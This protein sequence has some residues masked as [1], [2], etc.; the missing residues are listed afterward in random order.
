MRLTTSLS[1]VS[2]LSRKCG[3]FDVSQPYRPQRPVTGITLPFYKIYFVTGMHKGLRIYGQNTAH[4]VLLSTKVSHSKW[5]VN[6]KY[7]KY[8]QNIH[9]T[10]LETTDIWYKHH[11]WQNV[12]LMQLRG[13]NM[14]CRQLSMVTSSCTVPAFHYSTKLYLITYLHFPVL[15]LGAGICVFFGPIKWRNANLL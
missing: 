5:K 1:S 14:N 8:N 3:S 2:Q 11:M 15:V 9:F 4:L 7:S 6:Y 13:G 10:D 12:Q